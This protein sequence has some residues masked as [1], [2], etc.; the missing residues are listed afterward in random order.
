MGRKKLEMKRIEDKNSRLVTFSKRRTGL[1]KKAR[2]LSI[3]CDIEVAL[4]IFSSRGKL[5][6]FCGGN[7]LAKILQRYHSH[8][9]A[10]EKASTDVYDAE[11]YHSKCASFQTC[12]ELLQIV[13][14]QLEEPNVEPLRVTDLV[15]LEKQLDAALTQTRSRKTQLMMESVMT[16]QEKVRML[17]EK[18]ELLEKEIAAMGNNG[19]EV[20]IG[21][22]DLA[23]NHAKCHPHRATRHL[24]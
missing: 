18:N 22:T 1:I 16:L 19:N 4:I 12:A 11:N 17:K 9:E 7:S 21:F 20:V 2:E 13:E 6:E 15:Q 5:Y 14:R 3:L 23:T 24:L 8:F 10:E